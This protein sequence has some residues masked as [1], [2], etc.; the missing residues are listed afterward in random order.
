[1]L[2][3]QTRVLTHSVGAATEKFEEL[4]VAEDLELLADSIRVVERILH[5]KC[6]GATS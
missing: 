4:E 6:L 2:A 1:M 5:P 3:E